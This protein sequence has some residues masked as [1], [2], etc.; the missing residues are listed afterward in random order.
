MTTKLEWLSE[1]EKIRLFR[2][3]LNYFEVAIIGSNGQEDII[4]GSDLTY[5]GEGEVEIRACI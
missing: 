4:T 2:E 5:C 3:L 1:A